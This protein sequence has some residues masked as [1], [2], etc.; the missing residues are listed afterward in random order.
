[1]LDKFSQV[2]ISCFKRTSVTRP[3]HQ[4]I[5]TEGTFPST[6]VLKLLKSNVRTAQTGLL[7]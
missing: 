4:I 3:G 1:M 7:R 2:V 6:P 5:N